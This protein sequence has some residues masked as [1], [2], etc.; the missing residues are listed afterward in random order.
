MLLASRNPFIS[1]YPPT[2][3]PVPSKLPFGN[4]IFNEIPDQPFDLFIPP[5]L[6]EALRRKKEIISKDLP[7]IF[8]FG[9][10]K[11][12]RQEE[13]QT[14]HV[15]RPAFT[16]PAKTNNVMYYLPSPDLSAGQE[17]DRTINEIFT[18][19]DTK[20]FP[21]DYFEDSANEIFDEDIFNYV[22]KEEDLKDDDNFTTSEDAVPEDTI[23]VDLSHIEEVYETA[24]E[25]Y[26]EVVETE[27]DSE[28]SAI[29]DSSESKET[30]D[31]DAQAEVRNKLT[32]IS[33][34]LF[35][36]IKEEN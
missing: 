26:N 10:K 12:K 25:A 35:E 20:L 23:I 27:D 21:D 11:P 1:I 33:I 24:D 28:A 31:S 3:P 2:E 32:N 19:R 8:G 30:N 15:V 13:V 36:L 34:E 5:I 7:S 14:R 18:P 6:K 16:I 4:E 17:L 29:T 9:A 22:E